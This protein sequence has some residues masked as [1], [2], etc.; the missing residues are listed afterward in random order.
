MSAVL[1][2][3]PS[4][5]FHFASSH[6]AELSPHNAITQ[7]P[8]GYQPAVVCGPSGVG[9]GTLV[10]LL[11]KSYPGRFGFSV[12]HTT[13]APRPGEE[14]GREYYFTSRDEM[15]QGVED[16]KF[17]EYADVH[18]NMYGT[19]FAAVQRV[20]EG[21]KVC[22]LDIDVQGCKN[23]K[24][25]KLNPRYLFIRPPSMEALE[26]RL[27][28]RGTEAEQDLQRRLGNAGVEIEYGEGEGN[29][30]RVVTNEVLEDSFAEVKRV[31]EEWYPHLKEHS[32]EEGKGEE[33]GR[34]ED[35]E[36]EE[37]N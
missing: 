21:G 25:S 30:D 4:N 8:A 33:E 31:F 37:K 35:G 9:K 11:M 1:L 10:G 36:G 20:R 14:E 28:D 23:V 24:K 15:Q 12:S 5:V 29:F 3:K 34:P 19:S 7:S 26:D 2:E 16:G 27:R 6:F 17:I 13:R 18:G 32:E 22:I